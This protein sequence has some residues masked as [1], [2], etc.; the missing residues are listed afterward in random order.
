MK[1][2][3]PQKIHTKKGKNFRKGGEEFFWLARIPLYIFEKVELKTK[4]LLQNMEI[5]LSL[6]PV[7]YIPE[8][9]AWLKTGPSAT[10]PLAQ[11]WEPV[12]QGQWRE[13]V[14]LA[15]R[16]LAPL[17]CCALWSWLQDWNDSRK[18][19]CMSVTICHVMILFDYREWYLIFSNIDI[20]I[21]WRHFN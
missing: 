8:A 19:V 5:Q 16:P 7:F 17:G 21:C 10:E 18:H 4:S 12:T 6:S 2:K 11:R 9:L 14:S 1:L 15:H 20:V 3:W 13:A